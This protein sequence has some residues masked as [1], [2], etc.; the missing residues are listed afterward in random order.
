MFVCVGVGVSESVCV[1]VC[2]GVRERGRERV[3]SLAKQNTEINALY[4]NL[5][6]NWFGLMEGHECMCLWMVKDNLE[7]NHLRFYLMM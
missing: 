7:Y 4:Y 3:P 2:V 6:I 5:H 1:Y